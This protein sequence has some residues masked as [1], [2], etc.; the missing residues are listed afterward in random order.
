MDFKQKE[1]PIEANT[2]SQTIAALTP[3][4]AWKEGFKSPTNCF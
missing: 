1:R 3:V 2:L 4:L